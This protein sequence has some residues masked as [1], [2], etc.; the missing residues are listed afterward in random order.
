MV[1]LKA[2]VF[3]IMAQPLVYTGDNG[4]YSN[5]QGL[6]DIAITALR[7]A[8]RMH[9]M[10]GDIK[11]AADDDEPYETILRKVQGLHK[12]LEAV[13]ECARLALK[14]HSFYCD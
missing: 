5:T 2:N 4:P 12:N 11:Q 3:A 13:S 8:E 7:L 14:K 6:S 10:S 1:K 9:L